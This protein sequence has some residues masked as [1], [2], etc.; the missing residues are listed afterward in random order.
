VL[1]LFSAAGQPL[2]HSL[3]LLQRIHQFFIN[4]YFNYFTQ[5]IPLSFCDSKLLYIFALLVTNCRLKALTPYFWSMLQ[6]WPLMSSILYCITKHVSYTLYSIHFLV[7]F[8]FAA[9][10]FL[11]SKFIPITQEYQ[12]NVS[13][14]F[15][16]LF[17]KVLESLENIK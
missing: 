13:S 9:L 5:S 14:L 2:K 8:I 15:N 17:S 1:R 12:F 10:N 3:N 6:I 16:I 7:H 4:Y 11:F